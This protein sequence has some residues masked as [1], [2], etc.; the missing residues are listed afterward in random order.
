MRPSASSFQEFHKRMLSRRSVWTSWRASWMLLMA[1]PFTAYGFCYYE[2]GHRYQIPPELLRAI[3]RVESGEQGHLPPSLNANGTRDIGV[4][5]INS[6]W[7]PTL[8]RYGIDEQRL[9]QDACASVMVG[10]WIL[11][12]NRQKLGSSWEAVGAYNAGCRKLNRD[13]C[14]ALRQRYVLKVAR[15]AMRVQPIVR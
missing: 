5:Q 3:A 11:A 1:V 9:S 13:Q 8:A 10:A 7:L 4:M 14:Q 15:A 6:G 2:A 12:M